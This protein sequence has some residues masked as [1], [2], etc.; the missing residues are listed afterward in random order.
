MAGGLDAPRGMAFGPDGT[1]YVAEDGDDGAGSCAP[2]RGDGRG[3]VL[4]NDG[5]IYVSTC[6]ACPDGGGIVRFGPQVAAGQW[7]RLPV[8]RPANGRGCR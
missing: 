8:A 2:A 7:P 5:S 1:L 4:A 3:M 6:A